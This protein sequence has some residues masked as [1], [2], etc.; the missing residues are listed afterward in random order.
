M[1]PEV[2]TFS[3]F[4]FN[5]QEPQLDT[6]TIE[7]IAHGLSLCC[8]FAGHSR[9]FYSVAQHSLILSRLVPAEF[10]LAGLLHD[11]SE[12]Y[13]GDI[14]RPLKERLPQY[15]EIERRVERAIFAR[16]GLAYPLPP[17]VKHADLVM[18]A[19]E[20]RDLMRPNGTWPILA[21]IEPLP[22]TITP[23]DSDRAKALFL[24]RFGELGGYRR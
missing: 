3:G 7:D 12:A 16:F 19:T 2:L 10:A 8:R 6:I 23:M 17:A 14:T 13:L 18:L 5:F 9:A 1:A 22:E 24:H 21:G 4:Y 15:R 20:R 11:A